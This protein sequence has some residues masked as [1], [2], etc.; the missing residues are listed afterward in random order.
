ME[1]KNL[2]NIF[3]FKVGVIAFIFLFIASNAWA[4]GAEAGMVAGAV[5]GLIVGTIIMFRIHPILGILTLLGGLAY[6]GRMLSQ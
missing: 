2:L 4:G 3:F 5:G 6:I 1:S